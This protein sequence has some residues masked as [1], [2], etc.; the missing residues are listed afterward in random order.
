MLS[1]PAILFVD[2][3]FGWNADLRAELQR[4][5]GRVMM[6][7]SIRELNETIDRVSVELAVVGGDLRDGD[8]AEALATLRKHA[9]TAQLIALEPP[10]AESIDEL[11]KA[12][13]VRH[14]GPRPA[15][16]RS[17]LEAILP[18][19]PRRL[20]EPGSARTAQLVMCV[21]DEPLYLK[22]LERI[23]SHHGYRVATFSNG[24]QAL[25]SIPELRPSLAII[26]VMMPGLNGLNLAD[27]IL[28]T[29]GGRIPVVL[30]TARGSDQDIIE[31]YRHGVTY[32]ITKPCSPK[33]VLNI[34]DY[35]VGGLDKATRER[36]ETQL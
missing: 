17:L 25:Q 32:Y 4:R 27:E 15:D 21:D 36:L 6:A 5:G 16:S 22:S 9:P 31:G 28:E 12:M 35:L 19:F 18:L 2:G 11:A 23:L 29:Y 30:L 24:E 13:Q 33:T 10:G 14:Y 20:A 8:R 1:M 34:A 26:D 3:D 7:D